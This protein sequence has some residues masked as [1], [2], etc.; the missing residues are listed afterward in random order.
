MIAGLKP[1]GMALQKT[2][3]A[4]T[5]KSLSRTESVIPHQ[6]LNTLKQPIDRTLPVVK[7]TMSIPSILSSSPTTIFDGTNYNKIVQFKNPSSSSQSNMKEFFESGH[8]AL[9]KKLS[10]EDVRLSGTLAKESRG[11]GVSGTASPLHRAALGC[12]QL[13]PVNNG[14]SNGNHLAVARQ[15]T[16]LG[17]EDKRL[18]H[19]ASNSCLLQIPSSGISHEPLS[20][21]ASD[22][23]RLVKNA[24]SD[25]FCGKNH[26]LS[27]PTNA[28]KTTTRGGVQFSFGNPPIKQVTKPS[29]QPVCNWSS[30][31]VNSWCDF[32]TYKLSPVEAQ[33]CPAETRK[34]TDNYSMHDDVYSTGNIFDSFN[35]ATPEQYF[36]TS[37]VASLSNENIM[38]TSVHVSSSNVTS[39]KPPAAFSQFASC[40]SQ[41]DKV[42]N[43]AQYSQQDLFS[44]LSNVFDPMKVRYVLANHPTET[45]V[46]VLC[47]Y[48]L[49]LQL[50]EQ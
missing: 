49:D 7:S 9:A 25:T 28:S 26:G 34:L 8:L 23:C 1:P 15:L 48:I 4:P 10:D 29:M 36:V 2:K 5:K 24:Q 11:L 41:Y 44:K 18:S 35:L 6:S 38:S 19:Y 43:S 27:S 12:S 14:K 30:N 21:H 50:S 3:S 46:E 13:S 47:R 20:R 17:P 31:T 39:A 32:N 33:R 16:L 40:N 42:S 22:P 45:N 37:S